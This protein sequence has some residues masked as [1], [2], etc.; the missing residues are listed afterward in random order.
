MQEKVRNIEELRERIVI[1]WDEC[2][3]RVI[4]AAG[5]Q[6]RVR[7]EVCVETNGGHF[8]HKL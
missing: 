2:D 3:Q 7:L 8:E 6:W 5:N 1:V 4:D